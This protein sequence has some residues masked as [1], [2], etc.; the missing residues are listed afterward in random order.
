MPYIAF[1]DML[2]T[3]STAQISND[4]YKNAI[5]DFNN[6]LQQ[7]S[8]Y[9]DCEIY[10]YSDNAYVEISSLDD[11]IS[12]FFTLRKTLINRHRYFSAY[13]SKGSL[14]CEKV[15]FYYKSGGKSLAN[16]YSMK[17]TDS[18][19]ASIYVNQ[20][21]FK[22]IGISLSDEIVREIQKKYTKKV[23]CPSVFLSCANDDNYSSY[24]PFYDIAYDEVLFEELKYVLSD[25]VMTTILNKSAGRYYVSPIISMIKGLSQDIIV[26]HLNELISVLSFK[27]NSSLIILPNY[28]KSFP[29]IFIVSLL[30]RI[31]SIGNDNRIININDTCQ[32]IINSCDIP[33]Q[34][35]L[36]TLPELPFAVITNANKRNLIRI[37]Y[38]MQDDRK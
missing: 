23:I 3:R 2:G 8:S 12:F 36:E 31:L 21:E 4:E 30:D 28:H 25:Y 10:G 20:C 7:V 13:V 5:N 14:N 33:K 16:G 24:I 1:L 15:D 34:V 19:T 22:G 27:N 6:A 32:T 35:L 11:V 17:F 18:N 38:N 29:L 9:Y 37:L 26:N